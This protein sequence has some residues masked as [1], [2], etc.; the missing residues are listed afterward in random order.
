MLR[1]D[2]LD[3]FHYATREIQDFSGDA[4]DASSCDFDKPKWIKQNCKYPAASEP[5]AELRDYRNFLYEIS[6]SQGGGTGT[7]DPT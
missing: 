3:S 5:P 1:A 7:C 2:F 4:G 6:H